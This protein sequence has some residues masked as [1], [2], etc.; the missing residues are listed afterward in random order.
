MAES[1]EHRGDSTRYDASA[2]R[3]EV[4]DGNRLLVQGREGTVLGKV[5]RGVRSIDLAAAV[6]ASPDAVREAREYSQHNRRGS[7]ML[8]VGIA[9][10]GVGGGV[11]LMDGI[12][13]AVSIPA[14]TAVG[15]GAVLTYYGGVHLARA[16]TALARSIWWYNRDL[17]RSPE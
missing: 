2:L 8:A 3:V 15:A 6:G 11:A 9:L 4:R 13:L 5:G 17:A 14:W 16:S 1:Q 7:T 10:W 12:D